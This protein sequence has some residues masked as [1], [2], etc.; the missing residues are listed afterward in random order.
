MEKVLLKANK[1]QGILRS[2]KMLRIIEFQH[3][4][5]RTEEAAKLY[6]PVFKG[7]PWNEHFT[8]PQVMA[9]MNEQFKRNNIIAL[10]TI[11]DGALVGFAW[12]YQIFKNDLKRGT[13]F[14][15]KL[16]DFFENQNKVFYLQ[17]V[18]VKEEFRRQHIGERLIQEIIK[19]GKEKGGEL[20]ILST[21]CEAKAITAM[22][23]KIGFKNTGITRP[24]KKLGRSYWMLKLKD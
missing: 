17:E 8:V 24:P 14:S 3:D 21:N 13:R 2:A 9:I 23:Q 15:P 11:L 20:V 16:K 19:R 10:A 6:C 1:E 5:T 18:G 7:S 12:M 4:I 22:I